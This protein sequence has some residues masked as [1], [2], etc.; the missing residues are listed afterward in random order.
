MQEIVF[1]T[2]QE[3]LKEAILARRRLLTQIGYLGH[4][5]SKCGSYIG[6]LSDA[7]KGTVECEGCFA[8]RWVK[9]EM[10]KEFKQ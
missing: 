3:E 8:E 1:G 7:A 4:P 5:C 6:V 2:S 9:E 10:L